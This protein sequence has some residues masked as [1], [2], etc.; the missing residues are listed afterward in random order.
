MILGSHIG[1]HRG[2][3][4]ARN[5]GFTQNTVRIVVST[6][7]SSRQEASPTAAP[8]SARRQEVDVGRRDPGA[9]RIVLSD[10]VCRVVDTQLVCYSLQARLCV[11]LR[12]ERSSKP[13]VI[14]ARRGGS[15]PFPVCRDFDIFEEL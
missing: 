8:A 5:G 3:V 10:Y 14:V 15:V 1:G 4:L 9:R 7:G 12:E 13:D 6:D 2:A 11:Y